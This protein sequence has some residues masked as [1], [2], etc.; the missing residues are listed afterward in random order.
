MIRFTQPTSIVCSLIGMPAS[1]K[2]ILATR[3][4]SNYQLKSIF[5]QIEVID[6]DRFRNKIMGPK[7]DPK[8]EDQ[9]RTWKLSTLQT[10]LGPATLVIVDDMNYYTSMRQDIRQIALDSGAAYI[11]LFLN[12]SLDFCLTQNNTR[13]SPL[14]SSLLHDIFGK[15]DYPGSKYAWDQPLL[16]LNSEFF[17]PEQMERFSVQALMQFLLQKQYNDFIPRKRLPSA[18]Q[19]LSHTSEATRSPLKPMQEVAVRKLIHQIITLS[20]PSQIIPN[21]E[22]CFGISSRSSQWKATVSRQLRPLKSSY[23]TDLIEHSAMPPTIYNFIAFLEK[24]F[25]AKSSKI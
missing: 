10:V 25:A 5:Y 13:K 24:T 1:G 2:S 7:F 12:P 9:V 18:N 8:L 22:K 16:T 21:L 15:F 19:F 11:S 20:V 17:T 6:P 3:L 23:L 14:P 4:Q